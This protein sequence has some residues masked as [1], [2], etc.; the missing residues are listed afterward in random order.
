MTPANVTLRLVRPD[1]GEKHSGTTRHRRPPPRT[2]FQ[3]RRKILIPL[4][5]AWLVMAALAGVLLLTGTKPSTP[6]GDTATVPG[7]LAR[8]SAIIPLETDGWVPAT[9]A[10]LLSSPVQPGAHRVRILLELTETDASGLA[11]RAA[12]YSLSGLGARSTALWVDPAEQSGASVQ[13][14]LVFEIPNQVIALVLDGPQGA[15]LSLGTGHH[16]NS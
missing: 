11:F 12:D 7:G 10:D 2:L 5:I 15:S 6:F 9:A 8:I 4:A 3:R 13:A 14:T 16:T 1:D